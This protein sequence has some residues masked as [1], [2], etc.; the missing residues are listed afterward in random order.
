MAAA[1][2]SA[3]V[4]VPGPLTSVQVR[5]NAAGGSGQPSSVAVPLRDALLGRATVWSGPA[6]T[7]GGWFCGWT[8]TVSWSP[9]TSWPSS[10]ASWRT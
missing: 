4:T 10:A 9:A 7:T 8:V 3:K 1:L 6:S 5:V 2:T